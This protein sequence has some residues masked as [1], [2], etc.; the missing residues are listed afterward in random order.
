MTSSREYS[1][2][3][4]SAVLAFSADCAVCGAGCGIYD[5]FDEIM[6]KLRC[7][8][9]SVAFA[10]VLAYMF[11]ISLCVT[12]RRDNRIGIFMPRCWKHLFLCVTAVDTGVEHHTVFGAG[13][14]RRDFAP[15]V[16]VFCHRYFG[17][18]RTLGA[19]LAV[20]RFLADARAGRG[21]VGRP[22][23]GI[24]MSQCGN[25]FCFRFAT[26]G[27]GERLNAVRR[28]GR[29]SRYNALAVGVLRLHRNGNR[30]GFGRV[31][32]RVRAVVCGDV[33]FKR[34]LAYLVCGDHCS[35]LAAAYKAHRGSFPLA[36]VCSVMQLGIL[37]IDVIG[38]TRVY[39]KLLRRDRRSNCRMRDN[40]RLGVD[41]RT[42]N[43][44]RRGRL[45]ERCINDGEIVVIINALLNI[46]IGERKL[47]G[48]DKRGIDLRKTL[49]GNIGVPVIAC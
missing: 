22:L 40:G 33:I 47:V 37:D 42:T 16:I 1:H 29:R 9:I 31:A 28:A 44:I 5:R 39:C 15:V 32:A 21:R 25:S 26:V 8:S 3:E 27:A 18:V 49:L 23:R 20:V 7:E 11:G 45:V 6:R 43:D 34:A 46:R 48:G 38:D 13:V 30:L 17:Y 24:L 36:A 4:V 35:V 10:A 41:R 19:S 12:R 14:R 2:R